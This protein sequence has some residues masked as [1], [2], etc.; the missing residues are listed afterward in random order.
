MPLP[1]GGGGELRVTELTVT[2][3]ATVAVVRGTP[4]HGFDFELTLKWSA[5]WEGAEV[6]GSTVVAEAS[7]DTLAD[8][9][10]ELCLEGKLADEKKGGAGAGAALQAARGA[11]FKA[12]VHRQIGAFEQQMRVRLQGQP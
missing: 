9:A 6:K 2:G 8:G 10:D 12:M 7:M 4:R 3:D 5:D 11:A 1:G